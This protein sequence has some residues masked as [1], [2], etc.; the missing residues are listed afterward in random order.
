MSKAELNELEV[1]KILG[2]LKFLFKLNHNV[3]IPELDKL[4]NITKNKN[5]EN[6]NIERIFGF[7]FRR[8][9][10]IGIYDEDIDKL[11]NELHLIICST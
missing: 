11:F 7:A 2:E 3:I 5:Y 4:E 1:I 10:E 8:V 6:S 9:Q